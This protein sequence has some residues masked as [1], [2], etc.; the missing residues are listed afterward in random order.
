MPNSYYCIAQVLR[1][2]AMLRAVSPI[3]PRLDRHNIVTII[4]KELQINSGCNRLV[5]AGSLLGYKYRQAFQ[6]PPE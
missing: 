2:L 4:L 5:S 6:E 3:C 1:E